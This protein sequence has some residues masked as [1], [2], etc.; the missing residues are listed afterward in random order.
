MNN[1]QIIISNGDSMK[2]GGHCENGQLQMGEYSLKTH[3]FCIA[4]GVFDI[5]LGTKWLQILGLITMDLLELHM[6][7]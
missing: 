3:M 1:F 4:M 2:C 7:F 5:V 6:S